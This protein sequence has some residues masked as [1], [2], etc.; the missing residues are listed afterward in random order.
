[1]NGEDSTRLSPLNMRNTQ[2]KGEL[3]LKLDIV[4]IDPS[5]MGIDYVPVPPGPQMNR[6]NLPTT[7]NWPRPPASG[8]ESSAQDASRRPSASKPMPGWHAI[9][10]AA[11]HEHEGAYE[12]LT[13]FKPVTRI[14]YSI[15]IYY[16]TAEDL[17]RF[18]RKLAAGTNRSLP[19]P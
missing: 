12:Y 7:V 2:F 15:H 10:V 11:L 9:S 1:M 13:E 16:V 8:A 6:S 4:L 14:G 18:D 19:S 5:L 17:K 3:H